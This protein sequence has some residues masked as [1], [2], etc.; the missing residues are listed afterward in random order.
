[1]INMNR[2]LL[3]RYLRYTSGLLLAGTSFLCM[4][5]SSPQPA[6]VHVD[7]NKT[8]L[9]S[10][11]TPTLQAVVNP[12][13]RQGSPI[14]DA[15]FRA[16]QQMGADTVRYV[17]WFPY[18]KLVVAELK[19]PSAT[20]TSWDFSLI[21]P[22][23][24]DFL[25]ATAGHTTV[26]NFSTIPVWMFH[27]AKPV[28]YPQDPNQVDWDY[29]QGTELLDPT[30]KQVGDYYARLVSWYTHGGFT[31][32]R[33]QRHV[34]GYHYHFPVWE[35]LNEP[36]FEHNTTPE[37]YTRRYDAIVQAIHSVSPETK[38]MGLAL[39]HASNPHWYE[40]FLNPKN[41]KP[42]IPLDYISYHFYASPKNGETPDTW[43]TTFFQQADG[44]LKTVRDIQATRQRLSPKT[45]TDVD[46]IGVILPDDNQKVADAD[47]Y[48]SSI[49]K[50]YW[51]AAA[52]LYAYVYMGLSQQGVEWIGESQLVGYPSQFPSVTMVDWV[53][54][55]PNARYWVLHLLRKNFRPGDRIVATHIAGATGVAAEA[56]QTSTG[57]KLLLVN[58]K[59]QMQSITL[60]EAS[61]ISSV[62]AVD[63]G[64]GEGPAQPRA[65]HGS[66]L[67]LA[68]FAV[69]VVQWK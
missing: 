29:N 64:S 9:V 18:P 3:R 54:G 41:H 42:G 68:P 19:P 35:V 28:S 37:Q 15:A 1:M 6:S 43:Q 27:T 67:Q 10:R 48:I 53:N 58:R 63:A 5:Q 66:S 60:P 8:I 21:D 69:A 44:F 38:F 40:Y 14:H 26:M 7:W 55:K 47:G 62:I 32:E 23:T 31:D 52:A 20:A 25:A 45:K 12:M 46:E 33:G 24:K 51:N 59:N 4:A 16:L 57:K 2:S 49:P 36:D 65:L 39:A 34:S 17:P 30:A 22:M 61:S 13:L 56:F 11:S 50:I